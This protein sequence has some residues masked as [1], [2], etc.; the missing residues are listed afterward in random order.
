[1]SEGRHRTCCSVGGLAKQSSWIVLNPGVPNKQEMSYNFATAPAELQDSSISDLLKRLV[2]WC[3]R[4]VTR[5]TAGVVLN[6]RAEKDMVGYLTRG[7]REGGLTL[8]EGKGRV[9]DWARGRVS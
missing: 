1:M 5:I 2:A 7:N 9:R 6:S 3:A 4:I 8:W